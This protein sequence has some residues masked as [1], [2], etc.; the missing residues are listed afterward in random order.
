[1][2]TDHNN[3][4]AERNRIGN[5][6]VENDPSADNLAIVLASYFEKHLDRPDNDKDGDLGCS[7]WT[8]AKTNEA[9]GLIAAAV[10]K[11]E[12]PGA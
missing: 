9:L 5:I 8:L 1:M 4:E 2:N 7:K 6:L 3:A 10:A 12:N 11:F